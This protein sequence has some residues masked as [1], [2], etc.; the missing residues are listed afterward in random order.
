LLQRSHP[1]H[2]RLLLLFAYTDQR[3]RVGH[4][5]LLQRAARV[6]HRIPGPQH[7][8]LTTPVIV[9]AVIASVVAGISTLFSP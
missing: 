5:L 3:R 6:L 2:L 7:T 9:A 8:L 1:A 4:G